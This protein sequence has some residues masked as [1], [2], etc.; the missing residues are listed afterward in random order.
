VSL[1]YDG[2]ISDASTKAYKFPHPIIHDADIDPIKDI[3]GWAAQISAMDEVVTIQNSTAH[4][5]GALGI[6][7]SL[8]LSSFGC[9]RWSLLGNNSWYQSVTVYQQRYMQ[10]WKE[11]ILAMHRTTSGGR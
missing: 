10:S 9:W 6:K 4:M 8:L 7:T 1:Q 5:A 2:R 3:E 11:V